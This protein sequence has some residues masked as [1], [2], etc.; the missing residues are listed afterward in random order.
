[1]K[2]TVICADENVTCKLNSLQHLHDLVYEF[3]NEGS[4]DIDEEGFV[5]YLDHDTF[6]KFTDEIY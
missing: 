1:M 4:V 6:E 2:L 3:Y 5:L